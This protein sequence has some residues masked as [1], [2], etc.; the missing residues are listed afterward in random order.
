MTGDE[1]TMD[2]WID[3]GIHMYTQI[4]TYMDVE[5]IHIILVTFK[6]WRKKL[7]GQGVANYYSPFINEETKA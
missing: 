3:G 2:G 7:K 4:H 5:C 6:M 1:W